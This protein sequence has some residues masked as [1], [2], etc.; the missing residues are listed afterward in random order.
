MKIIEVK[1][2]ENISDS[3]EVKFPSEQQKF[4]R[5]AIKIFKGTLKVIVLL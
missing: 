3:L 1:L 2:D 5:F 4:D